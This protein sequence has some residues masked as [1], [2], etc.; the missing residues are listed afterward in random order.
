MHTNHEVVCL[1][2]G[3]GNNFSRAIHRHMSPKAILKATL[4]RPA[5]P[6]D[7]ILVND[8][9]SCVNV[10]CF[11]LDALIANMVH[12]VKTPK[13][14]EYVASIL[15]NISHYK[16]AKVKVMG[17]NGLLFNDQVT[18]CSLCDGRFYGGG[19]QISP[20]SKIN[21]SLIDMVI[22]PKVNRL[23]EPYYIYKILRKNLNSCKDVVVKQVK[24]CVITNARS[25]ES[26]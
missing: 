3:T 24:E 13:S 14:A 20:K 4:D 26:R 23:F 17:K 12:D 2:F 7:T 21:D 15:G 18:L 8:E 9:R 19:F 5:I 6:I 16:F 10:S 1:P 11:V 22:L 25:N